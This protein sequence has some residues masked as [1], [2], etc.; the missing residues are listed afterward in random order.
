MP[1]FGVGVPPMSTA[2]LSAPV[3]KKVA[4]PPAVVENT[5]SSFDEDESVIVDPKGESKVEIFR[6]TKRTGSLKKVIGFMDIS[7]PKGDQVLDRI[8]ELM[9]QKYGN[10]IEIRRYRK[11]TFSRRASKALIAQI[12]RE[13]QHFVGALAD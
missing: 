6:P 12:S 7:K 10:D 8:G 2:H 13:C 1:G 4:A 5:V 9:R 3:S 11:E